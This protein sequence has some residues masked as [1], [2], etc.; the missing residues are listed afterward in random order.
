MGVLTTVIMGGASLALAKGD[1]LEAE[2]AIEREIVK[3]CV[4][5]RKSDRKELVSKYDEKISEVADQTKSS[6]KSLKLGMDETMMGEFSKAVQTT[7]DDHL[8]E[9]DDLHYEKK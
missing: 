6:L 2:K 8:S 7:M 9:Y 1:T 5:A 4:G 3:A